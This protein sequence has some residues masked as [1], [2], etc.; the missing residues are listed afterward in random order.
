ML[1]FH[2]NF[3]SKKSIHQFLS[4]D[5]SD[6]IEVMIAYLSMPLN[7]KLYNSLCSLITNLY[8]DSA[9]RINREKPLSVI[10]F[11]MICQEKSEQEEMEMTSKIKAE[12]LNKYEES[13]HS[14][15]L[16]ISNLLTSSHTLSM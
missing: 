12:L 16:K 7:N 2:R 8:I 9:P 4:T 14:R 3:I 1:C 11:A 6:S 5:S 13:Y 10:N 15:P